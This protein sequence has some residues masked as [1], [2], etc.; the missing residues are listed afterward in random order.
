[1]ISAK[2][3]L[4]RNVNVA[5]RGC[6]TPTPVRPSSTPATNSPN[7]TGRYQRL[8]SAKMGPRTATAEMSAKVANV[9]GS[10]SQAAAQNSSV[11]T[12]GTNQI[13]DRYRTDYAQ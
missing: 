7:I 8:G 6:R 2:P 3:T 12:S 11:R 4:A 5:S 13:G 9:T 10:L 1:M